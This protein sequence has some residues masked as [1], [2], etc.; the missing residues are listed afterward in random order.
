MEEGG[1]EDGSKEGK[2]EGKWEGERERA[3]PSALSEHPLAEGQGHRFQ[4]RVLWGPSL[5]AC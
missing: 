3:A 5:R 1:R 2:K 4:T